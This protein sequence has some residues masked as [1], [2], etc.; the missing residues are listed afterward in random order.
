[1]KTHASVR[2]LYLLALALA[3]GWAAREFAFARER[4]EMVKSR[5]VTLDQLKM[6]NYEYEGEPAGEIGLYLA[7]DTPASEK[8][9][10]G[11]FVLPPGKSPHPPHTHLEEEVMIIESG[12]GEIVCDGETTQVGPGSVMY[13]APQAPHGIVNTGKTPIVFYFVKWASRGKP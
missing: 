6:D 8:F 1:M 7:G 2:F 12:E 13:T 10:T 5:T 4:A 3:T 11:R 9:V